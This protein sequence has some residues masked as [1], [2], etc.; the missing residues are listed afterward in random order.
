M[1]EGKD[2][3]IPDEP[4]LI[5]IAGDW[6]RHTAWAVDSIDQMCQ[7]LPEPRIILHA[8]DLGADRD[9]GTHE[10]MGRTGTHAVFLDEISR[11]LARRK[12]ELWFTKGNHEDH[13]LL[14]DC[15][16]SADQGMIEI[17]PGVRWLTQ[18]Y[19]W[20]WHGRTWL[21]LGGAASV[22]RYLRQEGVPG[23]QHGAEAWWPGEEITAM[24]EAMTIAAGKAEVML[25][26]DAPCD[27]PLE[28]IRPV[29]RAWEP[30]MPAAQAHR[31]KMQRICEKVRPEYFF[32][33]HYHQYRV[34]Q[35]QA[36]WGPC[37]FTS[38]SLNGDEQ[39][40]GILDIRT[41]QW[42]LRGLGL[43]ETYQ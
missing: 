2:M 27:A 32:H 31:E 8:G 19:R 25:T 28:L 3:S 29:P 1:K 6:H 11:A 22:D 21:A 12:A 9:D 26:H 30:A 33:G 5:G 17:V 42:H 23:M 39:N 37:R 14:Q 40:W 36:A 4:A 10:W 16:M 13:S 43:E 38:L 7:C 35:V 18:G 34:S 15:L 20:R 24:E 41:M